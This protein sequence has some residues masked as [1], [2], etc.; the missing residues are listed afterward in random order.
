MT[1]EN[2]KKDEK[3]QGT[4]NSPGGHPGPSRQVPYQGTGLEPEEEKKSVMLNKEED[5]VP[6]LESSSGESDTDPF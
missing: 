1:R 6:G 4:Q 3:K 2:G 5:D